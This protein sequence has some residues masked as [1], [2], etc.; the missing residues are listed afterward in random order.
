MRSDDRR[1]VRTRK[2]IREAFLNLLRSED[3][4]RV[5]ITAVAREADI[6]RKTFYLHYDSVD[7]VLDE[8]IR[9]RAEQMVASLREESLAQGGGVDVADLFARLSVALVQDYS[10]T[11]NM[12]RH[13][14][15]EKLLSKVEGPLTEAIVEC[16][17]L[18]LASAMGPYLSFGVSFLCGGLLSA[19]RH[20]LAIDSDMPL[21]NLAALTSAAIL[22]GV[23]GFLQGAS[24]EAK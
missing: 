6:D 3:Y 18:G 21:E 19:Y 5:T 11:E 4:D 20:W 23:E 24:V 9:E 14:S 22:A 1:V 13:V 15:P 2:A 10:I 16:D 12:V 17:A 7:D 8:F